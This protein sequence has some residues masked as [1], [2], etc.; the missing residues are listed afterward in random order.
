MRYYVCGKTVCLEHGRFGVV[1]SNCV[2]KKEKISFSIR[3]A[4]SKDCK[5]IGELVRAFWGEDVQ[6]AFDIEFVVKDLPAYV[7]VEGDNVIGFISYYDLNSEDT[8]IVALGILP[9]YQGLGIGRALIY[10]VE[11]RAKK[12]SKKRHLVSTTNDNLL[13]LAFY[14]VLGFQ[15]YEVVPGA[16]AKKHGKAIL[17]FNNIPIRDEIRLCKPIK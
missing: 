13:A 11:N 16:I 2:L 7:A 5:V 15:I 9:K 12:A 17:G 4:R 1:C 6:V 14:Q 10:A 3:E 8:L